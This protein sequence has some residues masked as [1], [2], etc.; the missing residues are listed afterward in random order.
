MQVDRSALHSATGMSVLYLSSN[1]GVNTT[2]LTQVACK[3]DIQVPHM[4][5]VLSLNTFYMVCIEGALLTDMKEQTA[6]G[7]RQKS[8]RLNKI[9]C[10]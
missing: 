4:Q 10:F 8:I 1:T 6:V 7:K 2:R 3:D 9:F 5:K